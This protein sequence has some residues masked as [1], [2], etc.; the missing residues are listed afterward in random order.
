MER[1]LKNKI[2]YKLN[3]K[4]SK[5]IREGKKKTV[6]LSSGMTIQYDKG[7]EDQI[8]WFLDRLNNVEV[9]EWN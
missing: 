8:E 7:Q 5:V 1:K 4:V 2:A 6:V 9:K 3:D